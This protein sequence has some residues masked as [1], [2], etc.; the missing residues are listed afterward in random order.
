MNTTHTIEERK[1]EKLD[2]NTIKITQ[3]EIFKLIV[4]LK[5]PFVISLGTITNAENIVVKIHTNQGIVGTGEGCPFVFIVGET[6]ATDFEM[7]QVF[8][9]NFKGKNPL[10][11]QERI[12][13]MDRITTFNSTVKSAFEV[14]LQDIAGKF[15][16][17]P[18]YALWGGKKDKELYTD[19]TVGIST[20]E[21]MAKCAKEFVD[22]GYPVI[23]VKLG[24]TKK[25]D[26]ARIKAIR[27]AIGME[28][29]LCIDA[30]QGWDT[31][32]AI[33]TLKMLEQYQITHC[34]EP[35][36][37]W[38]NLALKKVTE[39]SPIPIM[40]DESLF[41]HRDA[42]KLATLQAC[43][44]FNI[45]LSKAGGCANALKIADI[46]EVAGIQ[47]QVGGMSETRFGVTILAHLSLA[48]KSI[49]HHDMDTALLLAEDPVIGGITYAENGRV[50]VPDGPGVGADFDP[51]YL[52]KMEKIVI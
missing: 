22:Q 40:A 31:V 27:E 49:V 48:R 18:L 6:Q 15:A 24:T 13:D 19:M 41:D 25:E 45:K 33:S 52:N 8:A 35:V 46:A 23:K 44:Y 32:T 20:P 12:A 43:D 11:I 36:P 42:F 50:I 1:T 51:E 47:C 34:E 17:L 16:N 3:I 14:A 2:A 4:P 7:A 30:N 26:V 37:H 21:D 9:K 5:K 29:P 10:E 39:H 38:N 28:I